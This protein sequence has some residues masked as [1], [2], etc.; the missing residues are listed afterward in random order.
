M[1]A[2]ATPAP[3]AATSAIAPGSQALLQSSQ[4]SL[5]TAG[6]AHGGHCSPARHHRRGRKPVCG[7]AAAASQHNDDLWYCCVCIRERRH[8]GPWL[9]STTISCLT[10]GCGH[11]NEGCCL[12]ERRR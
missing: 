2:Y 5:G 11:C 3:L 9:I 1:N 6:I 4:A 7:A 12:V 8:A 10:P